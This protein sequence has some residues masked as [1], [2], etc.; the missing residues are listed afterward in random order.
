[1]STAEAEYI[2]A[3]EA[4]KQSIWIRHFLAD[5]KKHPK[6]PTQLGVDNQ[7]ALVLVSNLVNHLYSKHIEYTI[8]FYLRL[9]QAWRYQNLLYSY[10]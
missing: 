10:H 4:A 9:H 3:A 7:S 2:A 8:S 6:E 5:I 1:M